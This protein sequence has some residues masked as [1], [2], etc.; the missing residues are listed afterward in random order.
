MPEPQNFKIEQSNTT[1]NPESH[2]TLPK[3]TTTTTTKP[4]TL[5]P[6]I[7]QAKSFYEAP[8]TTVNWRSTSLLPPILR[9]NIHTYTYN[10]YMYIYIHLILYIICYICYMI[11]CTYIN[12]IPYDISYVLC[13]IYYMLHVY[14]LLFEW[15]KP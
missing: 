3:P 9:S 7:C 14:P 11:Y 13:T 10:I 15:L 8:E 4:G 1:L 5:S 6:R 12:C 2:N